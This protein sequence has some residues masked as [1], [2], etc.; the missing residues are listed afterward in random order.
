MWESTTGHMVSG[1]YKPS[2][3][4]DHVRRNRYHVAW[5]QSSKE[6][7]RD[8]ADSSRIRRKPQSLSYGRQI[9]ARPMKRLA[10]SPILPNE[11][12]CWCASCGRSTSANT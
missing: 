5:E 8:P 2:K 6:R 12:A 4:H 10:S 11:G 3:G 7:S 1:L 9:F